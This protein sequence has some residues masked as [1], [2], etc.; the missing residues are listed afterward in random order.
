TRGLRTAPR[1]PPPPGGA[2]S[3]LSAPPLP[4]RG[5][6]PPQAQAVGFRPPPAEGEPLPSGGQGLNL[7]SFE[8][9]SQD[10]PFPRRGR[11]GGRGDA[12][13]LDGPVRG[14]RLRDR[15]AG[16]VRRPAG[17]GRVVRGSRRGDGSCLRSL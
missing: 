16:G 11:R 9:D 8:F 3:S 13:R 12:D 2:A 6:A 14:R 10:E 4:G 15:L 7:R 17:T 5:L 1:F